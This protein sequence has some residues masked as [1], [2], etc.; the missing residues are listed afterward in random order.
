MYIYSLRSGNKCFNSI[1]RS[2]AD[3]DMRQQETSAA[4]HHTTR[5]IVLLALFDFDCECKFKRPNTR[6]DRSY[7]SLP[8]CRLYRWHVSPDKGRPYRKPRWLGFSAKSIRPTNYTITQ[9]R[10]SSTFHDAHG[11]TPQR[12]FNFLGGCRDTDE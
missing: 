3:C 2:F 10:I 11:T 8:C 1:M 6:L 5:R 7:H 4:V 9:W 12:P